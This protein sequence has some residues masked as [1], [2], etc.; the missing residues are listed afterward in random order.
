M[1]TQLA[2]IKGRKQE[3]TLERNKQKKTVIWQDLLKSITMYPQRMG[4]YSMVWAAP[5]YTG[6][7]I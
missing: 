6:E 1:L 3:T 5:T 7:T 2:S 4:T